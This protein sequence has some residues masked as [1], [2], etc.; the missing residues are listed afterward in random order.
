MIG[1]EALTDSAGN[2]YVKRLDNQHAV[3]TT[4]HHYLW[5]CE[6]P[7][8]IVAGSITATA[9]VPQLGGQTLPLDPRHSLAAKALRTSRYPVVRRKCAISSRSSAASTSRKLQSEPLPRTTTPPA[10]RRPSSG[11]ALTG[12]D[13]CPSRVMTS[14][15][16]CCVALKLAEARWS[17]A[18]RSVSFRDRWSC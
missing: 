1:T 10:Y 12:V 2:T 7:S 13:V 5:V 15:Y 3:S 16:A 4:L 9:D 6:N 18:V 8:P 17:D 11:R 14:Q